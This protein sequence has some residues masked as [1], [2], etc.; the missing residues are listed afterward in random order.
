MNK[1]CKIKDCSRKPI[2]P[3]KGLCS[4]CYQRQR[5]NDPSTSTKTFQRYRI[6]S[7]TPKRK[8]LQARQ[9]FS[10][11]KRRIQ[12]LLTFKEYLSLIKNP[13][14]YCNSKIDE[15]GLG[16]DRVDNSIGY[17]ITN[18]VSC[19]NICNRMKS[20]LPFDF[21]LNRLKSVYNN[22]KRKGLICE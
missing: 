5:S 16:L 2:Y 6:Y 12:F 17:M 8:F 11:G 18:V 19:C 4:R 20:I 1:K 9:R 7:K 22:L 3:R 10:T 21:F 15:M 14:F 13:C